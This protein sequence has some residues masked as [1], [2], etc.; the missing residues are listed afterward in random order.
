LTKKY[1]EIRVI[2]GYMSLARVKQ[3]MGHTDAASELIQKAIFLAEQYNIDNIKRMYVGQRQVRFCVLQNKLDLAQHLM[4]DCKLEKLANVNVSDDEGAKIPSYILVYEYEQ[5]TKARLLIANK[6]PEDAIEILK[7]LL[8]RAES[9]HRTGNLIE[10]LVLQALARFMQGN[11]GKALDSLQVAL[12]LARPAGYLRI[13]IDEGKSIEELLKTTKMMGIEADYVS[14]LLDALNEY[15]SKVS[16]SVPGGASLPEARKL[17]SEREI[18]IVRY[19]NEGMSNKDIAE[20]LC[21]TDGTVKRH[22]YN[23]YKKLSVKKR[24]QTVGRTAKELGLI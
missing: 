4:K 6:K 12:F 14:E 13:F 3:A 11:T 18:E 20:K 1:S 19:I 15:M 23:I 8:D 16:D 21:I 7:P 9:Q 24:A 5:I 2:N 22:K 17:L 10:M